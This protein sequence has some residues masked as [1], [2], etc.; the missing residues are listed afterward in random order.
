MKSQTDFSTRIK[1]INKDAAK[2][3][4]RRRVK[5]RL[6]LGDLLVVPLMSFTFLAGGVVLYWEVLERPTDTPFQFASDLT[7]RVLAYLV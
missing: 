5:P 7:A 2:A 4:R 3:E 6:K 1:R